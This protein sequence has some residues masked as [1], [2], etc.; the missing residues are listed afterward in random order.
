MELSVTTPV[1]Q[2][3]IY[4]HFLANQSGKTFDVTNPAEVKQITSGKHTHEHGLGIVKNVSFYVTSTNSIIVLGGQ[5]STKL[6]TRS[7][8]SPGATETLNWVNPNS[9]K[10]IIE[11]SLYYGVIYKNSSVN[12]M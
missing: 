10:D 1:Y 11:Y 7:F 5:N 12:L 8:S 2:N 6:Y 9:K 3:F 4:G